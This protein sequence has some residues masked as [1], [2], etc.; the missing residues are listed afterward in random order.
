M[1][2][3]TSHYRYNVDSILTPVASEDADDDEVM[4]FDIVIVEVLY[5]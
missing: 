4:N 2:N 5:M 1:T 3:R